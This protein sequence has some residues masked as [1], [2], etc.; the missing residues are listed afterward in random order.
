MHYCTQTPDRPKT[1]SRDENPDECS[2]F[3]LFNESFDTIS[4]T[5]RELSPSSAGDAFAMSGPVLSPS[6][7]RTRMSN[8]RRP[9]D[10][11]LPKLKHGGYDSS[12]CSI[13]DI[14]PIKVAF[15]SSNRSA[16]G[17]R[18][19]EAPPHFISHPNEASWQQQAGFDSVSNPFFVIRSSARAL[20]VCKYPLPCLQGVDLCRVNMSGFGNIQ[21][22]RRRPDVSV[23]AAWIHELLSPPL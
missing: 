7:G 8:T 3:A 12:E 17:N 19:V 13:G 14:S 9:V 16:T 10:I 1:R 2:S 4:Q 5:G 23:G 21:H 22:Y 20:Q 6:V 18:G 11:S 15:N